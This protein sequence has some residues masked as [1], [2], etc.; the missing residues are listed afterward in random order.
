MCNPHNRW[1]MVEFKR[2]GEVPEPHQAKR[3]TALRQK[4]LIT[5][6]VFDRY[7][8]FKDFVDA[9]SKP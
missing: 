7:D 5:V 1:V 2:A 4:N 8:Y 6:L 3:H 9:W